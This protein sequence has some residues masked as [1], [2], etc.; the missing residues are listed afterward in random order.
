MAKLSEY[1]QQSGG[2]SLYALGDKPFSIIDLSFGSYEGRKN[3]TITTK[4]TFIGKDLKLSDQA[5]ENMSAEE[6]ESF[7][8]TEHN[9]FH[10][11]REAIVGALQSEEL[12]KA[13]KAG[14]PVGPVRCKYVSKPKK[15][16]KPY[17][18]LEDVEE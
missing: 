10:T 8:Q 6:L 7:P 2:I 16:G 1:V 4:E 13:V 5:K 3:V 9:I 12:I 11:N 14:E 18:V 17:W 15:G